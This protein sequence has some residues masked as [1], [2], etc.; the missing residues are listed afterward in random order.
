MLTIGLVGLPNVG[1][2]TLFNALTAGGAQVSNY[3]F[4][5]ID[6]NRGVVSVPDPRLDRLGELLR[7]DEITAC[8]IEVID[9]AGLVEGASDGEGLGNQF[10]GEIRRVDA[11][12]HV[13]RSFDAPEVAHQYAEV[14]PV[15]DAAVIET[16]LLLADLEVLSRAFDKRERIWKGDPKGSRDERGR[17]EGWLRALEAGRPLSSL[18]CDAGERAEMKAL[19]MLTGKPLLYVANVSEEG[20]GQTPGV[21]A[22]LGAVPISARLEAE[23]EQ[24]EPDERAEFMEDLGLRESGLER[25]VAACFET[26]GLLRFYTVVSRKLRAW[27]CPAET[28]APAAA[29]QI[30]GDMELGF[31]RARV[32]AFADLDQCGSLEAARGAGRERTEGRAYAIRDGDLVEFLFKA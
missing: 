10:L 18:E 5:T 2:S 4:T 23:L 31:I 13:L 12:V 8:T 24:L 29:G 20:Y 27:E 1:K 28:L 25:M 14:D 19:G 21:P 32:V 3:P 15:R 26:L 16:E 9:I 6:S 7:P 22:P 11:V 17:W 30:H